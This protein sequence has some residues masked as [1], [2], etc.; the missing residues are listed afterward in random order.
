[1]VDVDRYCK[2]QELFEYGLYSICFVKKCRGGKC[3]NIEDYLSMIPKVEYIS[4]FD[5]KPSTG[6][7]GVKALWYEGVPYKGKLTK[8]FAYIGYPKIKQRA[9]VPAVVLV[10]GGGGHAFAHW[11][12][13]WNERGYAAISMDVDG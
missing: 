10:H 3:M 11:V 7:D 2:E 1:M 13:I 6:W 12:K 4:T 8:V 9:K 5:P